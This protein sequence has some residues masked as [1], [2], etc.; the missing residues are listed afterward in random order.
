MFA[1]WRKAPVSGDCKRGRGSRTLPASAGGAATSTAAEDIDDELLDTRARETERVE[2]GKDCAARPTT[3]IMSNSAVSLM[4]AFF[5]RVG[6]PSPL[7]HI[8]ARMM[9]HRG[10]LA[11]QV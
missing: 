10:S 8:S 2:D 11:A 4:K 5:A 9:L 1:V 7:H 6:I 3:T